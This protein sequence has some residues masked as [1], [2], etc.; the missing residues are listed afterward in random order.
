MPPQSITVSPE[1]VGQTV[2]AVMRRLLPDASWSLIRKQIAQSSVRINRVICLDAA[3]RLREGDTVEL[4]AACS[5]SPSLRSSVR[6]MYVDHHLAVVDKPSGLTTERRVEER[7]WPKRRKALAPTLDELL[8][9]LLMPPRAARHP[10]SRQPG[11]VILVHRLDRDTSGVM[12]IARTKQAA[13]GLTS[14]FRKHAAERV[15]RAVVVGHPGNAEIIS[16]LVRDRGDGLRG[17]TL[18]PTQ[19][20]V[21]ITHVRELESI[22]EFSLVECRLE[23]GRTNQI[24]IHLSERNCPVCGDVKYNHPPDGVPIADHSGAPR[25]ALHAAELNFIHPVSRQP[26]QFLA[27]WPPDLEA[28]VSRLR[29]ASQTATNSPPQGP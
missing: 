12:V 17:S 9:D 25:L 3:R 27:P 29:S 2:A 21:A 7:S 18:S 15:Y 19:G 6:L 10:A 14:Q 11:G 22:G 8:P 16:R 1:L 26:L 4:A 28:L 24:R 20:Q 13:Q 23:T 5:K